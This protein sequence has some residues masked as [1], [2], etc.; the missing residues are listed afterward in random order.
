[1]RYLAIC[2]AL[3]GCGGGGNSPDAQA[4]PGDEHPPDPIPDADPS[5]PSPTAMPAVTVKPII[6]GLSTAVYLAQP[7]GSTDLYVVQKLGKIVIVRNGAV[8]GTFVDVTSTVLTY[9]TDSEG[10]LL[11]LEFAADYATSGTFWIYGSFQDGSKRAAVQRWHATGDT[12]TFEKELVSFPTEAYNSIGGTVRLGPDGALW[13]ATGDNAASPSQAPDRS[14]RLGKILRMDPIT[15]SPASGNMSGGDPYVWD[16][17]LR[18]PYRFTFDRATGELYVADPGDTHY[19]EVDVEQPG[20]GHHDY[21]WDRAEGK[22]CNDGSSA[23]NIG[24]LPVFEK[25]HGATFS[26]II[27]GSVY[28]GSA[29]PNL[30]CRYLYGIFGTGTLSSFRVQGAAATNEL[31]LTDMLGSTDLTYVTSIVED[32]AGELYITT[33]GGE[34]YELISSS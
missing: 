34:V 5:C 7:P 24:T 16:Y 3:L 11:G 31:D 15:G 9:G 19:E 26:V 30:R 25:P 12:A 21:G 29:I 33:L 23:C 17:G 22:H 2:A 10:G 32:R 13:L 27:G 20:D 18:N 1:M 6:S 14:S 28:R 8:A 4:L